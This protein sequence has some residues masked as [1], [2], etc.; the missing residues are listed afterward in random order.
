MNSPFALVLSGTPLE[1]RLE[2]LYSVVEFIDDRRLGPAFQFFNTY[3]IVSEKGKPLGY[4]NLDQLRKK[5]RPILLRRTRNM[6]MKELP[7]RSTEIIRITPTEEQL[8]IHQTHRR[9]VSTIL[10]KP[11]IS[12]MDLL[13]LRKSLLMCRLAANS[14]FLVDKQEPGYSTKLE[15]IND[16]LFGLLEEEDRK[17]IVFSEWNGCSILS[18]H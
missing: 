10:R 1:N 15:E 9:V 8:G 11:Y 17:I 13:R 5:L 16:L 2:E 6:V 3:K 4:K 18:S 14:T 7:P 12:E